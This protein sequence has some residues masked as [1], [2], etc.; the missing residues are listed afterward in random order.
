VEILA[1]ARV[2]HPKVA[3]KAADLAAPVVAVD[4]AQAK[5]TLEGGQ[6]QLVAHRVAVAVTHLP[7][8]GRNKPLLL[9]LLA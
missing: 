9:R 3:A 7:V 8:A 6:A 4:A 5:G 1:A 2:E